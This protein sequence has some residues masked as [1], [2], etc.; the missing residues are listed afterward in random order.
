M[1]R[2]MRALAL[3]AG[4]ALAAP[5][6][7]RPFT[8]D[9]MLRQESLGAGVFDPSGRWYVFEQ[10]DR[11]DTAARYDLSAAIVTALSRLRV[12]E[13]SG[14]GPARPLISPD[15]GPGVVLGSFSPSGARLA[16]FRFQDRRWTLGVVE[17]ARGTVRWLDIT[18]E[19]ARQGR[20]LQWLSDRE[21]LVLHRPDGRPPRAQYSGWILSDRLPKLWAMAAS[22]QGARTVFGSGRYAG[23]RERGA[24]NVLLRVDALTG[25]ARRLATGEFIDLEVSPDR[26]R[27]ALLE[28]GEDLQ[29]RPGGPARGAAGTETEATRLSILDLETAQRTFPCPAC[30]V[31]PSLL[32]WS[33]SGDRLLVFARAMNQLWTEGALTMVDAAR[34][35][36]TP[37]GRGVEPA[38]DFNSAAVW[39][40]W[41]GE[42]PLLF[43]RLAGGVRNDWF[44]LTPTAPVNL[45][46][47]LEPPSKLVRVADRSGVAVL[48]GG[49]VWRLDASGR[50]P[51]RLAEGV[52]PVALD[53]PQLSTGARRLRS[54]DAE[55]W[56]TIGSGGGRQLGR[57][58][59]GALE[60]LPPAFEAGTITALSA[61]G[62]AAAVRTETPG[63]A[64]AVTLQSA[65]HGSRRLAAVN[66]ELADVDALRPEP[67]AHRGPGGQALVSWLYL[68]SGGWGASRSPLIVRPYLGH[69]RPL[70]PG[71]YA[72]PAGFVHNLRV[73]TGRGYAVLVP[74]LPSPAGR[75]TDPV[76]DLSDPGRGLADRILEIVDL[77]LADPRFA[78]RLD[79]RRMALMGWSFGGY[80][81]MQ[82]LTQ[83]HRF[84]AAVSVAGISDMTAYW[85][86]LPM[87][88]Q[89]TPEE[90]YLSNWHTGGVETAQPTLRAPPWADPERYRRNSPLLAAD[91]I[92]TPLL[93]IHGA[94]DAVPV[95]Q[96]E[97]M[98]TALFRQRKDAMLVTYWGMMHTPIAPGDVRD[99]YDRIFDFLDEHVGDPGR[100]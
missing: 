90:G 92:E 43:G 31:S 100:R 49:V 97:A 25:A 77:T 69:N 12:A 44:R 58:Q 6:A 35:R 51:R 79:G 29:P 37:V 71:D 22:G 15:P 14:D 13:V 52:R 53:S 88:N 72:A 9:D 4:I 84:R 86:A 93:L 76:G 99:I 45:T 34:D 54:P 10:R 57:L 41:L 87:R 91:K 24:P 18:P 82:T 66:P 26:R 63:G 68:P 61:A 50:R 94:Q 64:E 32:S 85:S 55:V 5:A 16:V 11:Y 20:S 17:M 67:I 65:S 39:T 96:S 36:A 28:S 38:F 27:V 56:L 73:L 89:V 33:P 7:A 75:V 40:G 21:L 81:V 23:V 95:T 80:T 59:A 48:S 62:R 60:R 1:L 46:A 83:T 19:D 8:V 42:D 2:P 47:R 3:A 98:Y 70:P 74:S 30:D 78:D